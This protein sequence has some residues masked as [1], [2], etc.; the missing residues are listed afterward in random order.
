MAYRY[1]LSADLSEGATQE[2]IA[3]MLEAC[4]EQ[5]RAMSSIE[6]AHS[7][8]VPMS[9][10]RV[11]IGQHGVE[12]RAADGSQRFTVLGV[13][14][15]HFEAGTRGKPTGYRMMVDAATEQDAL[16]HVRTERP[17]VIITGIIEGGAEVS[18][19]GDFV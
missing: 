2:T 5:V 6:A 8:Q 4:A 14:F 9:V 11:E 12:P 3:S 15:D 1:I 16:N 18:L 10:R 13:V 19:V 7:M 17:D